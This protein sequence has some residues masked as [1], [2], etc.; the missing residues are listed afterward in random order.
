M[1]YPIPGTYYSTDGTPPFTP[2]P[3]DG[4]D[5]N[6]NEPYLDVFRIVFIFDTLEDELK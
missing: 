6:S 4:E 5:S 2:A 1:S 3:L